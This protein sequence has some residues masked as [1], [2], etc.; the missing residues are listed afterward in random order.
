AAN[1][2]F[3]VNYGGFVNGDTAASL[4]GTLSVTTVATPASAVGTYA[5]TPAGLTSTNYTISFVPG[6]LTVNAAT[7]TV[8]V[9]NAARAYGVANPAF[10]VNYG[11]FVNGD[12]AASLGGTLSVTTVATPASAVGTYA[13]TPAGLTS[14]NY[15]ISYVAGTLTVN[16]AT[17]TVTAVNA[18]RAYGVA[19]P[20]FTVNYGGFVNG[21]TAASL[22]G[23]LSVTT[24]ATP[25]SAVGTY[26]IT[27][28]GLTSTNYTI[29]FVPGTL[30]VN[31]ATLTVTVVN[32]TRAYGA[33][34]PAFTVNYG[35]FVN[36]DTAASLGG[37][38]S[39]TTV[40]TPASAVG[41]YAIT[42]AG[43]TSTNYTIS[44]V[45]G[46]LTVNA[47]TLTVTAVN[48]ARAY[49]V[50][51]PAFTVNY[52]G[53]VNGDTAASLG[54]TLSVTTVATPASAVGTY[55][56]TPAGLT[57]TNYTISFVPGTLTVN[58]ATLTVTVVNAARAYGVANPAFTVNYGGFVN[59]DTAASLGGTLSVT[60]VATPASA[61]G[62]YAIT[63]AGLTSTNY[64]ISFVPGTLTVNAATLTVTVVNAT[65][66]YGAANPAFTVNYGGFVNGDTAASL[67]GTLSVTT[68]A[69]PAS[70]VGT[71]AITPAGLTSTNYTISYVAGTLTVNAA[72]LTV[73][74]VNAARAY[75]VANPA[76]TVNYGGFVNGD[77]AASLGGTL[78]V[79]TVA[80]P[81]SAVGTYAITPAGLTSTNYAISYVPG[82]LT[83]NAATL[84][85]TA[86][87]AT[88]AY[89]A[90]NPAFTVTYGGFVNGD[91]AASL[92]GTLTVTSSAT[93]GSAVG[94]Y[95]ITPAGLTSTNYT[96]SY[97][98]GTLTVNAATLTVTAVNAT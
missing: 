28:A 69:T 77:T 9:V 38:L 71:Y 66:A 40:A 22:G 82:T 36:G 27:P 92:G 60:T 25:A 46:T 16:A 91:T 13:I 73:T 83:V 85:V 34:N 19:N 24:V 49:G 75:G 97:V 2:A 93:A 8:T 64:T 47:A 54:G 5:I 96:I 63:P 15:T 65:R 86:V 21:D 48:A 41:T 29:S 26:A 32:A 80:T 67:G 84:T 50:A 37:T 89:G 53:F 11:G 61:V 94:T 45:A 31:A 6:T 7:L 18:A 42:P 95:A 30:T 78:S 72:T 58:A 10:T 39:V 35:G 14:T 76:F 1:P 70:A 12:T 3:T 55:A 90:A 87:N 4:G 20:A 52:G 33:A 79:T 74:A 68:V 44:Y 81:A 23:T 88:R 62:T 57:S 59:G 51:N 17:L 56:I 43:L 98:A